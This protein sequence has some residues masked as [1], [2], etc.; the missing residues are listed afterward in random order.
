MR[1]G[2]RR[3]LLAALLVTTLIASGGCFSAFSKGP[4]G[5]AA[6]VAQK[7]EP[8][9]FVSNDGARCEV[10]AVTYLAVKTGE[11][12]HCPWGAAKTSAEP[13]ATQASPKTEDP[14]GTQ[15]A[16]WWWPFKKGTTKA[17]KSEKKAT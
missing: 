16:P 1:S 15:A 17:R 13:S 12:F 14:A 8:L 3:S 6:I 2:H 10:D 9:M 11:V 4:Y 5:R 7:V